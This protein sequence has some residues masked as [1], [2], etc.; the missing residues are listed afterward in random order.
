MRKVGGISCIAGCC[1]SYKYIAQSLSSFTKVFVIDAPDK[2]FYF[3][4]QLR[5][6]AL[7]ELPLRMGSLLTSPRKNNP[8]K[9]VQ[10]Q[11]ITVLCNL[12]RHLSVF[13]KKS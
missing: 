9:L 6:A 8:E 12:S 1:I 5:L 2:Q 7:K 4:K 11:S 10:C 13:E 3:S